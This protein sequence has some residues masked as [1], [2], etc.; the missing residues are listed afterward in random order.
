M[1]I[2]VRRINAFLFLWHEIFIWFWQIKVEKHGNWKEDIQNN[3]AK[4]S[5]CVSGCPWIQIHFAK[6][7][8]A[9]GMKTQKLTVIWVTNYTLTRLFLLINVPRHSGLHIN[10]G[11]IFCTNETLQQSLLVLH[12]KRCLYQHRTLHSSTKIPGPWLSCWNEKRL[13]APPPSLA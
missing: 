3:P 2:L 6:R 10:K 5:V 13:E 11:R 1:A 12:M 4:M 9:I 7:M 8:D